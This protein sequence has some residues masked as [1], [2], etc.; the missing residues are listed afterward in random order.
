VRE[1]RV[2]Q[3]RRIARSDASPD[4]VQDVLAKL[5]V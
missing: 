2:R 4:D 5:S 3:Q 1:R